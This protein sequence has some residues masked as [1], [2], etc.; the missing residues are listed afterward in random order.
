MTNQKRK[1]TKKR[2]CSYTYKPVHVYSK[3]RTQPFGNSEH[4][5]TA[6][7]S[8]NVQSPSTSDAPVTL[9]FRCQNVNYKEPTKVNTSNPGKTSYSTASEKQNLT[10]SAVDDTL[11]NKYTYSNDSSKR[12]RYPDDPFAVDRGKKLKVTFNFYITCI[13]L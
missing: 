12:K 11:E 9:D 7:P 4:E 5:H 10:I 1:I 3:P 13:L 8:P 6:D 2:S